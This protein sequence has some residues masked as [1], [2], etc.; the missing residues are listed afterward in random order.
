MRRGFYSIILVVNCQGK[1]DV[2]ATSGLTIPGLKKLK[3]K[4]YPC[5]AFPHWAEFK[6]GLNPNIR[7]SW[8]FIFLK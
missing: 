2:L 4:I 5:F 7:S 8:F 6:E 3:V 1:A